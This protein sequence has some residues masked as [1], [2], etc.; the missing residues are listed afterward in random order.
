[1][2]TRD[3]LRWL[4]VAVL[5]VIYGSFPVLNDL[6]GIFLGISYPPI[7]PVLLGMAAIL[8]KLLLIDIARIKSSVDNQRL[9]QRIAILEA[10]LQ[11]LK[12][13]KQKTDN[14]ESVSKAQQQDKN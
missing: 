4:L 3:G 2:L 7:I 13:D 10:E 12:L 6:L 9:V 5:V 1:M 8:V 11:Q 14:T